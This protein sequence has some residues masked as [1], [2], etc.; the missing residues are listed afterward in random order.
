ME[1]EEKPPVFKTWRGWYIL[2]AGVLLLVIILMYLFTK[3][4]A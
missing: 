1:Q 2:V 3:N 4:F